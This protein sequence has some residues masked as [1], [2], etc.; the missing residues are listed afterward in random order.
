MDNYFSGSPTDMLS[1]FIKEE[2]MDPAELDA[3][4]KKIKDQE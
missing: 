4:L 1:F 3:L 2:K